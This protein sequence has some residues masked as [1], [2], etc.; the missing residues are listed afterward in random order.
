M[1]MW[2]A[3]QQ[4]IASI[5]HYVDD[6][7]IISKSNDQRELQQFLRIL[8]ILKVPYKESK[9][10]GPGTCITFLGVTI[11]TE[12]MSISV[13]LQKRQKIRDLLAVW[14]NRKWCVKKDLQSLVS[15]L[16]WLCQ[17]LPQERPFVQWFIKT[18]KVVVNPKHHIRITKSMT[19]DIE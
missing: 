9:L 15:S 19:A 4:G 2:I 13:P 12:T 10:E 5:I 16:I 17:V 18:Q 1:I 7:L 8:N 14:A 11:D 3:T 6:F